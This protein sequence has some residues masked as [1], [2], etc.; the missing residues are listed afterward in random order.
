M[1]PNIETDREWGGRGIG[2]V[3]EGKR[4]EQKGEWESNEKEREHVGKGQNTY[5]L[6]SR[7][8]CVTRIL[9]AK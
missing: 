9:C 6:V 4:E 5:K 3:G 1:F 2:R 8:A 7:V